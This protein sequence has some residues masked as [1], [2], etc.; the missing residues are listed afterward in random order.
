MARLTRAWLAPVRVM[1][2]AVRHLFKE[3]AP[4]AAGSV[5][6]FAVFSLFPLL[7]ILVAVGSTI[8]ARFFTQEQILAAIVRLLP[9]SRE[10]VSHNMLVVLGARGA[11]GAIG[12]IGLTWS[13]TSAFAVLVRNLNRA[14]PGAR[15]QSAFRARLNALVLLGALVG[16]AL[17]FLFLKA[18]P[19][20]ESDWE[21]F[22]RVTREFSRLF[23]AGSRLILLAFI[24]GG[25]TLLY[26]W[27]PSTRVRWLEAGLGAL[28]ATAAF[29]AA[30]SAFTWYLNSGLARYNLV[31]GSLGTLLALLSWIYIVSLVVLFGAHLGAA[32]AR[33][34]RGPAAGEAG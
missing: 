8:L 13:A 25:L 9:V 18:I 33:E 4:E 6:F 34:M 1:V 28:A 5:G 12:A 20:V 22:S 15:L 30:T 27:V 26:R 19:A 17:L 23:R 29:A 32:V 2:S 11:V 31:Y 16:L 10:L 3:R 24:L 21:W 7:L 14:W